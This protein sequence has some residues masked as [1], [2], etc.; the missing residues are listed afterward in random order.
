MLTSIIENRIKTESGYQLVLRLS[1]EEYFQV[2]DDISEKAADEILSNYLLYHG[3]DG[4]PSEVEI[5]R[6]LKDNTICIT[7]CLSYLGNTF[8]NQPYTPD[9]LNTTRRTQE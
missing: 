2:Y 3:D 1:E 8:T 4:R 5:R 7:A 9:M 6:N